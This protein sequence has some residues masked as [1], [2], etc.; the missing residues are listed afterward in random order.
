MEK[1]IDLAPQMRLAS[2]QPSTVNAEKRTIEVTWST[3]AAVKRF[4]WESYQVVNEE[5]SLK[6]GACRLDRLNNGAPFLNTHNRYDLE[7]VLG[8]IE[9]AW[10]DS[11]G[12]ATVRFHDDSTD[13]EPTCEPIWRKIVAGIVRNVSVGYLVHQYRDVTK[14]GDALRTLLAI[15]WEPTEL[16]AV[17]VGADAGAGFRSM[18]EKISCRLIADDP[19]PPLIEE[20]AFDYQTLRHVDGAGR[21]IS[22]DEF[23][24]FMRSLQAAGKLPSELKVPP[25]YRA[26]RARLALI[27]AA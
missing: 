12:R 27:N 24:A 2:F 7:D 17:P 1:L 25:D 15:D 14:K 3:G 4:D 22:T 5:L 21:E 6:S 11:A 13:K 18:P 10:I 23:T 20:V 8:V 26:L 16:S 19:E 9:K